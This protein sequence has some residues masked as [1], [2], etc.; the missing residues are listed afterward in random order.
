MVERVLRGNAHGARCDDSAT[1]LKR[2]EKAALQLVNVSQGYGAKLVIDSVN[3]S[4]TSGITALLGPNG[5]GKTTLLRTIATDL[6]PKSGELVIAGYGAHTRQGKARARMH[7]GYLP[8]R[9]EADPSFTVRELVAYSAWLRKGGDEDAAIRF[10][11][12]EGKAG[13]RIK[14]LSGGMKQ[15][16]AIAAT[17]VGDPEI[18]IFDEPT[19]GLDPAQRITFRDLLAGLRGRTVILSTHLVEDVAVLADRVVVLAEGKTRF[20]GPPSELAEGNEA[21]ASRSALESG[22]LRVLAESQLS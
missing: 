9:F 16:A 19:V 1:A 10:V 3:L 4:F 18:L 13:E 5:A 21:S 15:R 12:L 8:Q 20:D 6:K 14:N 7:I 17:I 22:Y 11:G 2:G